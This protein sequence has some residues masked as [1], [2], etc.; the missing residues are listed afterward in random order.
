MG[1]HAGAKRPD[2]GLGNASEDHVLQLA[3][4]DEPSLCR[5][6]SGPTVIENLYFGGVRKDVRTGGALL[7]NRVADGAPKAAVL[8][9]FLRLD[10]ARV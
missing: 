6:V 1:G 8:N 4:Q 2:T 5:R 3:Q 10:G 9:S 7:H